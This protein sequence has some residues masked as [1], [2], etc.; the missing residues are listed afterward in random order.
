[1]FLQC[2]S[3]KIQFSKTTEEILQYVSLYVGQA[4]LLKSYLKFAVEQ[5]S[6]DAANQ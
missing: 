4:T 6:K 3:F 5:A 2:W 1:M